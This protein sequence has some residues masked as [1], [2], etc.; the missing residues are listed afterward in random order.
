MSNTNLTQQGDL[1]IL[2]VKTLYEDALPDAFELVS[3]HVVVESFRPEPTRAWSTL[4]VQLR[5]DMRPLPLSVREMRLDLRMQKGEF[6]DL[7][8]T[9]RVAVCKPGFSRAPARTH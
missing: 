3:Q 2:R 4:E 9:W 7:M 5:A 6:L 8:P 1:W